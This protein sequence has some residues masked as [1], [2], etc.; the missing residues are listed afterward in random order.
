MRWKKFNKEYP[1]LSRDDW[2]ALKYNNLMY[3]LMFMI[4]LVVGIIVIV[5]GG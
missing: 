1:T 4:G 3:I 2:R 5:L